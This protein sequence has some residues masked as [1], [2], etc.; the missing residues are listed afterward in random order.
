[1]SKHRPLVFI[2]LNTGCYV[3][4]SHKTNQDGYFRWNIGNRT[5]KMFHRLI[6][7]ACNGN[8]P[9]GHEINHL[10]GNRSCQNIDHMECIPGEEH[11]IKTNKERFLDRYQEALKYWE[12]TGCTG[13]ALGKAF[14]V[15]FSSGCKWVRRWSETH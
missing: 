6:W 2:E 7:E 5:L 4:V 1:M 9:E 11:V 10:C 12:K 13:T 3:C 15:S 14:G 8:I